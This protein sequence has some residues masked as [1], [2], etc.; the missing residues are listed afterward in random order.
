MLTEFA[1]RDVELFMPMLVLAFISPVVFATPEPLD[2][3]NPLMNVFT[4][5]VIAP[6]YSP[7]Q[8]SIS[9]SSECAGIG[10]TVL[11]NDFQRETDERTL[12]I[13][14]SLNMGKFDENISLGSFLD[15]FNGLQC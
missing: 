12:V 15:S 4:D 7:L 9:L 3:E 11:L 5:L 14:L 8:L 2:L 1:S 13:G 6:T 10:R